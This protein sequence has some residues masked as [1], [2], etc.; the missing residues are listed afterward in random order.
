[1]IRGYFFKYSFSTVA[2][3][4]S[5]S[6]PHSFFLP[7][8]GDLWGKGWGGRKEHEFQSIQR[9]HLLAGAP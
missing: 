3:A 8:A 9:S 4:E 1:M 5:C 2:T 7:R 6:N